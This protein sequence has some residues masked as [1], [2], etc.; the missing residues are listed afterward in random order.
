VTIRINTGD[1]E[2]LQLVEMRQG[3][4]DLNRRMQDQGN[5]PVLLESR[6]GQLCTPRPNMSELVAL[7]PESLGVLARV[8]CVPFVMKDSP[9][10]GRYE[11]DQS[12]LPLRLI[13]GYMGLKDWAG[14]PVVKQTTR[15]PIIRPD[16]SVRWEPGWDEQTQCWVTPG[17]ERDESL[18][19]VEMDI[20]G[21]FTQFALA[22]PSYIT[23]ILAAAL[24]P[25]MTTAIDAPYPGLL[26]TAR[27]AGSGKT[28]LAQVCGLLGNCGALPEVTGWKGPE[29][30]SN[31]ITSAVKSDDRLTVFDNIKG[32]IDSA[33][34]E[35][36]IT[37]RTIKE[38]RFHTQENMRLRSNTSWFMT[39]NGAAA[40]PDMIRRCIV[41]L[42]DKGVNTV[43]WNGA[44]I[45][46]VMEYERALVTV[47]VGMIESWRGA[48]CPPG[49]L[50]HPGFERWSVAVS[51]VLEHA[52]FGDLFT[53]RELVLGTA[54]SSDIED[55]TELINRLA[56]VMGD[57][58][59]WSAGDL[60]DKVN[61]M[62]GFGSLEPDC[63][64]IRRWVDLIT[65]GK[66]S[67]SMAV[68]WA[69]GKLVSNPLPGATH[70]IEKRGREYL[71]VEVPLTLVV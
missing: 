59:G 54:V 48:G 25:Y 71:C 16:F 53:G 7:S 47:M 55:Q 28:Y 15:A 36:V 61:D 64:Y 49:S 6:D 39:A 50:L 34:L 42:L 24:T 66:K 17:V 31:T 14:V 68:G 46:W 29:H 13:K 70:T 9:G 19:E 1:S 2:S 67:E 4:N 26:V 43:G 8:E 3:L 32:D 63:L 10:G 52:G 44:V 41:T 22:D 37:S 18:L 20:R 45:P 30:M 33:E 11:C 65:R 57:T 58:A 62:M 40:S 5:S 51:G 56:R 69:L 60:F 12:A 27:S 38:R 21:V 23:D 35:A